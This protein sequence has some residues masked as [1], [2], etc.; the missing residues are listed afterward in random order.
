MTAS[1]CHP[2]MGYES[3]QIM[4]NHYPERLG[5]AICIG[6]GQIFKLA[7]KAIKS[8]LPATTTSK[9]CMV[10]DKTKMLQTFTTYFPNDLVD[11]LMTEVSF[12]RTN[13]SYVKSRPFWLEPT[14]KE[15]EHDPRGVKVYTNEWIGI[16]HPSGHLP[17]PNIVDSQFGILNSLKVAANTD[18]FKNKNIDQKFDELVVNDDAFNEE[19]DDIGNGELGIFDP[20]EA[21]INLK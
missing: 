21:Q 5:L 6:P 13:P 18:V 8:I 16:N 1:N 3:A 9:I 10:K 17:H 19:E 15:D 12:N 11:W 14:N 20:N 7:W 4:S 2:R